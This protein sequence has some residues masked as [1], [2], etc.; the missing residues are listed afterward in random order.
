[1]SNAEKK[2]QF[3]SKAH[4]YLSLRA[5]DSVAVDLVVVAAAA[6]VVV[7]VVHWKNEQKHNFLMKFASCF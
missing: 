5:S 6:A 1:L 7:V 4:Y 3:N 2:I